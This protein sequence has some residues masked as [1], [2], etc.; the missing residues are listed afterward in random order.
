[1][2]RFSSTFLASNSAS[3]GLGQITP[4]KPEQF[5]DLGNSLILSFDPY[6][7]EAVVNRHTEYPPPVATSRQE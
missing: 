3:A 7:L 5:M 2:V 1:M 6:F 4:P